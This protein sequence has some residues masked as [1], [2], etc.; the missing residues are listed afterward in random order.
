MVPINVIIMVLAIQVKQIPLLG[1]PA[2]VFFGYST[3]SHWPDG[4]LLASPVGS[5]WFVSL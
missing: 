2:K 4:F 1:L 5:A 3:F